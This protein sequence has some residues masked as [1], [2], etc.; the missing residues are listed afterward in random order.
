MGRPRRASAFVTAGLT[1]IAAAILG[2]T[3]S[4][5]AAAE[6]APTSCA[7][8]PGKSFD[9]NG[10]PNQCWMVNDTNITAD[11]QTWVLDPG[12]GNLLTRDQLIAHAGDYRGLGFSDR[13]LWYAPMTQ[14]HPAPSSKWSACKAPDLRP[15]LTFCRNVNEQPPKTIG[16]DLTQDDTLDAIAYGDD[17]I[18]LACGN[19]HLPVS[20][21]ATPTPVIHGFKFNDANRDDVQDNGETGLPGITFSLSRVASLVGQPDASN[22]AT[23]ISDAAG[24]FSFALNQNEGPG[25]YLVTEQFSNQWPNTTKLSQSIVVPEGAGNGENLRRLDF[26]DR[27]EIPPV[28][29]ATPQQVDQDSAL[30][31]LVTLDGSASYSPTGDPLTYQW[32]GPFRGT[33]PGAN[34][35]VVLP[36]GTSEVTLTVSDGIV[37]RSIS[38]TVTVY[39]PITATP[40]DV[41]AVEGQAFTAP[42]ATFTDPDPDGSPADYTAA[43][44]WGDGTPVSAGTITKSVDGTFTVTAAEHTYAEEGSYP[45]SVTITDDD[46]PYNTDTAHVIGTVTDAPLAATGV[47]FLST[48]PVNQSLASFKD[49]NPAGPLS[50]F[51]AVVDWGDGSPASSGVVTGPTGGPFTVSGSHTYSSLGYKTITVHISDIGGST[52]TAVDHVLLYATSGFV[53]GDLNSA[54]GTHVTYW[55]AQWWKLNSLTGGLAPAAFKG[56]Q[57]SPGAS[58]TVTTWTTRPGNSSGPPAT[59]P[60]FISVLVAGHI[61]QDGSVISGDAPHIVIVQ[62]DPGYGPDPGHSGTGTV[63]AKLR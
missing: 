18:A 15:D 26:G 9:P 14:V 16:Q 54:V 49:S 40:V 45:A 63:V 25:T 42:V 41:S 33:V 56:Y 38:T 27:E 21:A 50:D 23:A 44:D 28:P 17:W 51:T 53:I 59:V 11:R 34:P 4:G 19:Y 31:A 29:I 57:D 10:W 36:P 5:P 47:D 12:A 43:I 62:T 24:N 20:G 46:V 1:V 7:G 61:T 6:S 22:L 55:G 48:N 3:A 32:N 13:F 8:L 58:N 2:V 30:G 39:P 52:A 37:S 60:A 35:Q